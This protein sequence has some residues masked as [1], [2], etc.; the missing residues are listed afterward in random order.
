MKTEEVVSIDDLFKAVGHK[1]LSKKPVGG[2][3]RYIYAKSGKKKISSI[4]H[5]HLKRAAGELKDE[6]GAFVIEPSHGGHAAILH[7]KDGAQAL[8]HMSGNTPEDKL[9]IDTEWRGTYK[10][11]PPVNL[12][13]KITASLGAQ[14]TELET[15]QE[16]GRRLD[17]LLK[18]QGE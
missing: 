6:F 12:G 8:G 10:P 5:D 16:R 4:L 11:S 1:Y 2:K 7:F 17:R 18:E 15:L 3:F 13:E 14:I 9:L